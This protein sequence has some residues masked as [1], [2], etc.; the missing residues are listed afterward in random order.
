MHVQATV[1]AVVVVHVIVLD[2]V[3]EPGLLHLVKI[4]AHAPIQRGELA[5]C[6]DVHPAAHVIRKTHLAAL[7]VRFVGGALF[8]TGMLV[9]AYNVIKTVSGAKPAEAAI[10]QTA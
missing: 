8:L 2:A 7:V 6:D 9:M 4:V 1:F 5:M 3:N 10:P